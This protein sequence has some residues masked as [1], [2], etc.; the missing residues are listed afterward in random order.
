MVYRITHHLL[1]GVI[2]YTCC[3]NYV[4]L[5]YWYY[6]IWIKDILLLTIKKYFVVPYIIRRLRYIANRAWMWKHNVSYVAYFESMVHRDILP[7][8]RLF[9]FFFVKNL[10]QDSRP[11]VHG[12]KMRGARRIFALNI[13][14]GSLTI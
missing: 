11:I 3:G 10:Y 2:A 7:F 1:D 14:W 5:K 8:I 9:K 13:T 12:D 4:I 6:R